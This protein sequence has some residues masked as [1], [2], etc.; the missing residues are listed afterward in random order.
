M[1]VSGNIHPSLAL[2]G[3]RKGPV[4]SYMRLVSFLANESQAALQLTA[5]RI[6][7]VLVGSNELLR[8]MNQADYQDPRDSD[9]YIKLHHCLNYN[10]NNCHFNT[11]VKHAMLPRIRA[12]VTSTIRPRYEG[13][14]PSSLFQ[15][16]LYIP[17]QSVRLGLV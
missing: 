16:Y 8:H 5:I 14:T 6:I 1:G 2:H 13:K 11:T 3:R 15:A 12:T 10:S 9:H 4:P 7:S 17:R